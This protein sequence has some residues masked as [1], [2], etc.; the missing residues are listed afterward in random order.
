MAKLLIDVLFHYREQEK[1][2]RREFVVMPPLP[3]AHHTQSSSHAA[4]SDAVHQRWISP[5]KDPKNQYGL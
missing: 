4:E 3:F 2:L 1:Y 5:R